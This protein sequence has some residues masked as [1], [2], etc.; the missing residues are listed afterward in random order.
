MLFLFKNKKGKQF[1]FKSV[2]HDPEKEDENGLTGKTSFAK[3]MYAK[4]DRVPFSEL[5][6]QGK[7]NTMRLIILVVTI[8][9]VAI[10]FYEEIEAKLIG[11]E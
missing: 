6:K 7:K 10:R 8:A 3:E 5:E 11:L 2:Y 1:N 9:L 4:W